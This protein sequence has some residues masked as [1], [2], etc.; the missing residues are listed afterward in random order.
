[1]KRRHVWLALGVL[2]AA[3]VTTTH[4]ADLYI[5]ATAIAADGAEVAQGHCPVAT[6]GDDLSRR[7]LPSTRGSSPEPAAM[8]LLISYLAAPSPLLP[9]LQALGREDVN[10]PG[11]DRGALRISERGDWNCRADTTLEG[12]EA[13]AVPGGTF[14]GALKYRT[15]ITGTRTDSEAGSAFVNGTR[16]LWFAPG[17]GLV[18]MRYEHANGKVTE[19][20]LLS[21]SLAGPGDTC[22]PLQIG[23]RWTYTWKNDYRQ[24]AVIETWKVGARPQ[25]GESPPPQRPAQGAAEIGVVDPNRVTLDLSQDT[26]LKIAAN[27]KS[28][29]HYPYYLFV[30][31]G[32]DPAADRH[33]FVETNNTGTTSDDFQVHDA[34]AAR[35]VRASYT[36]RIARELGTPLLVPV[37]PRPRDRWQIYTHSLDEDTLRVVS[38]PLQRIDLQLIRMIR[39]AQALLRRNHIDVRDKVFMHGYSASGVF[40]NRFPVLHPQVVRAVAT[41]GVNAIPIFP[42]AQWRGTTLPFPVGIADL[43]QAAGIEFDEPAYRQISQYLYMGYL[44]R[45]DTTESRD[46]FCE[47]HAQLIRSLMGAEMPA[48]WQVSQSIY[49]ELGLPAQ[50][51]TYNGSGH[52]IKAEMIDD[53]VKFFR[54]NSGDGFVPI[55]P[56][57]YPF[58]EFQEIKTAHVN[59]LYWQGD[60][61]IP[62]ASRSL[63]EGQGHFIIVIEEWLAGQDH[64]QLRSFREKVV[65]RFLLH[66]SG[67][68][69]IRLTEEHF[70]GNCSS[71]NGRFQGFVVGLPAS[72]LAKIVPGVGYTLVPVEQREPYTLQVKSGVQLVRP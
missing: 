10:T 29:F 8:Y 27:P 55:Q 26:W 31:K 13:V 19:A 54:A 50:C 47:E 60:Q 68:E 58:V 53:V 33:L 71:G 4:G 37:F 72:E 25:E 62:A 34:A 44:D 36:N 21:H 14:A 16:Y 45:N 5:N 57:E 64:R 61:R 38:G 7:R 18:R 56:H 65:F 24:E 17:V 59:G 51:V 23:N 66:A 1:M 32:L 39:E 3:A 48:R 20:A 69:D 42:I 49:R 41:G 6:A 70:I 46:A 63:F 40:A 52:E 67:Q 35:L 28:G 22:L 30:P 43:K 11:M 2:G 9:S 12:L 15:V